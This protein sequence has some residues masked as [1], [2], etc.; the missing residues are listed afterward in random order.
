MIGDWCRVSQP[1]LDPEAQDDLD[2]DD[3]GETRK[4]VIVLMCR[5][6]VCE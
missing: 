2:D 5:R 4:K 3:F 6:L 1:E